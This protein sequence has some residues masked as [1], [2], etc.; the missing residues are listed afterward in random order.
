MECR[1]HSYMDSL[2][3]LWFGVLK[4]ITRFRLKGYELRVYGFKGLARRV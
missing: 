2:C 1:D 4:W 3:C